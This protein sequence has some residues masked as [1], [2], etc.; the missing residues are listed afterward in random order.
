MA[1]TSASPQLQKPDP[2]SFLGKAPLGKRSSASRVTGWSNV[3]I[4]VIYHFNGK[5]YGVARLDASHRDRVPRLRRLGPTI[6]PAAA[7]PDDFPA[8]LPPNREI[9][10]RGSAAVIEP[11]FGEVIAGPLYDQ[12]GIVAAE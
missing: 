5:T 10:G 12:A 3:I 2:D 4:D 9:F 7:F 6:I 1:L 11:S 8:A